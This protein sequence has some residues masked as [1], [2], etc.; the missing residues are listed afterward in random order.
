MK[1]GKLGKVVLAVGVT[2]AAVFGTVDASACLRAMEMPVEKKDDTPR[3]VAEAEHALDSGKNAVATAMMLKKFPS[4]KTSGT[5]AAAVSPLENRAVRIVALASVRSD[6][7]FGVASGTPDQKKKANLEW[8]IASLRKINAARAG[9]ASLQADLGE[10]LAKVVATQKEALGI[11]SKLAADDLIG[12]P[13]AYAALARLQ[14]SAGDAQKSAAAIK[15]CE[16][17]TTTPAI[18]SPAEKAATPPK[19]PERPALADLR[20]R[21]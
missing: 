9:D 16:G 4:L 11:L 19:V 5:G 7:A 13:Y 14:V 6:G 1:L 3:L 18:C 2:A 8:S 20:S 15:R 21:A 17:M 10:A 12:S